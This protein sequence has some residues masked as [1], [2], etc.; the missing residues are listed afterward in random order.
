MAYLREDI[1]DKIK[2]IILQKYPK[3]EIYLYWSWARWEGKDYPYTNRK[4]IDVSKSDIDISIKVTEDTECW[5]YDFEL[6]KELSDAVL[7]E[8]H[9]VFCKT[10]NEWNKLLL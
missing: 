4:W 10:D 7:Y 3:S 6:N 5:R 8:V 1:I 2:D 9:C